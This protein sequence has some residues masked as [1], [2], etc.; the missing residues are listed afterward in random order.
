MNKTYDIIIA[1]AGCA[2]LSLAWKLVQSGLQRRIL[3]VDKFINNP[4]DKTWCYWS[5]ESEVNNPFS[6][7]SWQQ[8]EF[9]SH[10]TMRDES[11]LPMR[12]HMVR[13]RDFYREIYA[14]L[15]NTAGI[16][17]IE[18]SI[19]SVRG[20]EDGAILVAGGKTY[21]AQFLFNSAFDRSQRR[22][23]IPGE[24]KLKQHF[25]GWRI[26]TSR[27]VFE[28]GAAR[29][30]DFRTPQEGDTRFFYVL[31]FSANEALVEY[32][33][34]S[35]EIL[36]KNEYDTA[37]AAY[38]RDVLGN[39]QFE[40]LEEERGV[41]PMYYRQIENNHNHIIPIGILGGAIK[42]STGYAYLL[43][44]QQVNAIVE[45]LKTGRS[46]RIQTKSRKRFV[47]YDRLLLHLLQREGAPKARI[48][49][50]LFAGNSI[51]SVLKFLNE[52]T[53][54]IEEIRIF[55]TLPVSW[56]LRAVWETTFFSRSLIAQQTIEVSPATANA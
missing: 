43:I 39:P 56:F 37:I 19:E 25:H 30:M 22:D 50:S 34:F 36:S 2:G 21:E 23:E 55:S 4:P 11:I 16:D 17:M 13:S 28:S 51:K 46:P 44:Q 3:I 41:I 33:V 6:S 29:L 5:D 49:E 27:P 14:V 10:E 53:N 32:T 7:H 24:N 20:K 47:F 42:P 40:V 45:C 9:H 18:A 15:R 54:L 35:S 1:G 48:F 38:I 12:Y 31:P 26:R 52:E 8:L